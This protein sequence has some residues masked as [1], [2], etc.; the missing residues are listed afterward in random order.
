LGYYTGDFPVA[1]RIGDST[2]SLPLYPKLSVKETDYIIKAVR[3]L[4]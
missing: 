3:Q 2:I 1:E 4:K